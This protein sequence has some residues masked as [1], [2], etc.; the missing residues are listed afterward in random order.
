M[1]KKSFHVFSETGVGSLDYVFN[2]SFVHLEA[3][4]K[5]ALKSLQIGGS[6]LQ[7]VRIGLVA[8]LSSWTSRHKRHA[9]LKIMNLKCSPDMNSCYFE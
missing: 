2:A 6:D 7:G 8:I 9:F 1:K 3:K 4:I 5:V